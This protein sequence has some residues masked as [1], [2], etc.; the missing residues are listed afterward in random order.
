MS[1]FSASRCVSSTAG[2][3]GNK[4][5]ESPELLRFDRS[6]STDGIVGDLETLRDGGCELG[7]GVGEESIDVDFDETGVG[8]CVGSSFGTCVDCVDVS[9]SCDNLCLFSC[10]FAPSRSTENN[11]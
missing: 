5:D 8:T 10:R 3:S 9:V 2:S 11:F 7:F 6:Q 4:S 1:A